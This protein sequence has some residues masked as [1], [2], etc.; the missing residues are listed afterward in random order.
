GRTGLQTAVAVIPFSLAS[1]L[2]AVLVV[3]LYGRLSPRRIA[4]Y[5]FLVTAVGVGLLAI[6]IRNEWSTFMVIVS[7]MMAGFGEGALVTLLFNV[8]VT[9]SPKELADDM[10]LLAG[11]AHKPRESRG[12]APA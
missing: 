4:R 6:V 5:A 8:L 2:T 9:A 11:A 12:S 3:R 1:F 10:G 7:M